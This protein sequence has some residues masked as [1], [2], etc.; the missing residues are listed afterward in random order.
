MST[1]I[2]AYVAEAQAKANAVVRALGEF[3]A[4]K[5]ELSA[6]EGFEKSM[7][8]ELPFSVEVKSAPKE[9]AKATGRQAPA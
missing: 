9:P 3:E 1:H 6:Q 7:L 2:N 4:A 8:P 5:V